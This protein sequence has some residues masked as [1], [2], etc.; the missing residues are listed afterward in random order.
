MP[1]DDQT[2]RIEKLEKALENLKADYYSQN[3]PTSQDHSKYVRFNGRLKVPHHSSL[4]STCEVGEIA[5]A[6][7]KL[8]ICSAADTWTVAGTQS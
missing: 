3:F 4:P 7:G 2:Q 5:E 8:Y 1:P 6:S